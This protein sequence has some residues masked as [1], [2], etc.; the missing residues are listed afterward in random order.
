MIKTKQ[1]G[2]FIVPFLL[3]GLPA[4]GSIG[5]IQTPSLA[6]A[7]EDEHAG[8]GHGSQ[9]QEDHSGHGHNESG[10][11][12]ER[13]HEDEHGH[14]DEGVIKIDRKV[15]DEFVITVHEAGPGTLG[16]T[17]QVPGEVVFNADL[18]AH[19]TP[20]VAGVVQ[21]V[22][23]S[24]SDRVQA[25]DVMAVLNSR[26]FA[27]ARSDYLA[28]EARLGLV[29]DNLTRDERLFEDKIGTERQVNESRQAVREAQITLNLAEQNLHALGLTD[30][31]VRAVL[32]AKDTSLSRYEL[33]AP[34]GGVVIAREMARGEVVSVQPE[35]SPFIIADLS[36]VWVNLT[37]Y[38]R[39]LASVGAGLPVR[40]EFGH[41]IPDASGEI[42]WVSPALDEDTRTATAR[43]VL[44]NRSGQWRP[45][46]FVTAHIA[47]EKATA[48]VVVPR[49]ALQ[50]VE[51]K[52]VVFVQTTKGYEPRQVQVGQTNATHIE[53]VQGLGR[54]DRYVSNNAFTIKAEMQK[55]AFGDGHAH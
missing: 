10:H 53:I 27:G 20:S 25:G 4:L 39:D 16:R 41:G 14:E 50:I 5:V 12:D 21:Q 46:L 48:A 31:E 6:L 38:Q 55:G 40:I 13:G 52:T 29:Q 2:L 37:I 23:K 54:G 32:E 33:R 49:T 42:A 30:D 34:I 9:E 36:S 26:E 22:N 24:V 8:H 17:I 3:A 44:D 11:D 45:G 43:I 51:G 15:M 47:I 35:E 1:V 18:I 19:V 28:A 7:A